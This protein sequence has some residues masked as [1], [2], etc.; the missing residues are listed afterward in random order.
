MKI[1][2]LDFDGVLNGSSWL[3]RTQANGSDEYHRNPCDPQ[4]VRH[5]NTIIGRSD[6]RIVISSSW[7]LFSGLDDLHRYLEKAG[8]KFARQILDV[9]PQLSN[10]YASVPP[11]Q[12]CR[13]DEIQMWLDG[14]PN[15]GI[16]HYVILDDDGDMGSLKDHLVQTDVRIG[17][18]EKHV[19]L[20][21]K[22]LGC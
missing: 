7:R 6:A 10:D 4:L 18:T 17:L 1:V 20:A 9:T 19:M 15:A 16:T 11:R 12:F 13:G 3:K 21:L 8:F 14:A 5:L 2:F 22:L